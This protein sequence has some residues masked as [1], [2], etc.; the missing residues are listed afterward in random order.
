[1]PLKKTDL[2]IPLKKNRFS[3]RCLNLPAH[4]ADVVGANRDSPSSSLEDFAS[5]IPSFLSG[6]IT[7]G[8]SQC[9]KTHQLRGTMI[10]LRV[11][12]ISLF[13]LSAFASGVGAARL[14]DMTQVQ[15]VRSNQLVG[16]GLVVGLNGTGDGTQSEFTI[17]S[18]ANMM[19]RMGMS[20]DPK[21]VKVKNTAGVM[22]T[23][24]LPPSVKPGQKLDVV[25]SSLGDSKSLQ[26][27]T[28]LMTPLK[29][30]DGKI[31]AV[32]Q[33]PVSLGGFS[34]GGAAGKVQKN[35]PTACRIPNG[36]TVEREVPVGIN[37]KDEIFMSFESADFTTVTRAAGAINRRL[38]GEYARALDA[39]TLSVMVPKP[40]QGNVVGLLADIESVEITP[41]QRARVVLDERTG[42][43]VMGDNVR[44]STVAV[45]HGNLSI[46]IREQPQVSQPAPFS[47]GGTVVVPRTDI[48][49]QEGGGELVLLEGGASI[50]DLVR[51]LNAVGVTPRDMIAI[52]HSIKA[53][54]ALQADLEII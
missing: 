42:T 2:L 14:K 7:Q 1:M 31:Y 25:V 11:A 50:G 47:Q 13:L 30:I 28:L 6:I 3:L 24:Q 9:D 19:E 52:L 15:G 32:A 48:S 46:Q 12:M 4:A 29:G 17:Q 18:L 40:Y 33:G 53:A 41:D 38:G 5:C 37:E 22:V 27:G 20:I 54:G 51:A 36:A 34:A 16:Y 43:V 39:L 49:V 10:I 8:F 26:G 45:A 35:H 44:I 23:A 21:K